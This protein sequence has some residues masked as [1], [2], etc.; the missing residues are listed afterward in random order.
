MPAFI[1]ALARATLS[2]YE[3]GRRRLPLP[4]SALTWS[5]GSRGSGAVPGRTICSGWV[6]PAPSPAAASRAATSPGPRGRPG[7]GRPRPR[8][9][10]AAGPPLS[11]SAQYGGVRLE[12][13]RSQE[14]RT[15]LIPEN[16]RSQGI[17]RDV[18]PFRSARRC[19]GAAHA[20]G[21]TRLAGGRLGPLPPLHG[22]DD[23]PGHDAVLY[24]LPI[25]AYRDRD[26][27]DSMSELAMDWLL[28]SS[29]IR[30]SPAK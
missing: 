4:G 17:G 12:Q 25:A 13:L 6:Q 19:T 18:H 5:T 20:R 30:S 9:P 8:P 2:G 10:A 26:R 23:L 16:G 22:G 21:L 28:P 7:A 27:R 1:T 29:G 11:E 15:D 3:P 14:S 24:W